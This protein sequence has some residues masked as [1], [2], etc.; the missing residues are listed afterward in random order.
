MCAVE[1]C[2]LISIEIDMSKLKNIEEPKLLARTFV[3]AQGSYYVKRGIGAFC[4]FGTADF[5]AQV[6]SR[7]RRML[8]ID[9]KDDDFSGPSKQG[10]ATR[11]NMRAKWDLSQFLRSGL[12]GGFFYA[13]M[14]LR[15]HV[16]LDRLFPLTDVMTPAQRHSAMAKRFF[17]EH[18]LFLPVL[19]A[20]Y[21]SFHS[22]MELRP[23]SEAPAR[24]V[25][26]V[27]PSVLTSWMLWIPVQGLCYTTLP[28]FT[29]NFVTAIVTLLWVGYMADLNRQMRETLQREAVK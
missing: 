17:A 12:F 7:Y 9:A 8:I 1:L 11:R 5:S 2:L 28:P 21:F 6:W 22:L 23:L 25:A 13:P 18:G 29:W 27:F 16:S 20:F 24:A 10:S 15:W 4:L 3:V 19:V 14:R 26:G